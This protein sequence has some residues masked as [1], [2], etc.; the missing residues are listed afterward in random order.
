M[1]TTGFSRNCDKYKLQ[2]LLIDL[3]SEEMD[4]E[5]MDARLD[6]SALRKEVYDLMAAKQML[7][8]YGIYLEKYQDEVLK[9][10]EYLN[11]KISIVEK[12]YNA[13]VGKEVAEQDLLYTLGGTL[14]ER[15]EK[16]GKLM[17]A[18]NEFGGDGS[19]TKLS[20]RVRG[21]AEF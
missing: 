14:M 20:R 15:T 13:V 1:S 18:V 16:L 11:N 21:E 8:F 17:N 4:I 3:E 6:A 10:S 5:A 19:D 12:K 7:S 2:T 9:R